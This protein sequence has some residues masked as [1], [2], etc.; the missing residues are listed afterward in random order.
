MT[1]FDRFP[2]GAEEPLTWAEELQREKRVFH[3]RAWR[4]IFGSL[5][6][7]WSVL[8]GVAGNAMGWW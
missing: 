3:A 1:D 7:F 8:I 6:L 4:I 2:A 5:A